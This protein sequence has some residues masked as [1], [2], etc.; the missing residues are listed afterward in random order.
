MPPL[1]KVAWS[2]LDRSA[3]ACQAA[4]LALPVPRRSPLATPATVPERP[5]GDAGRPPRSRLPPPVPIRRHARIGQDARRA[6]IARAHGRQPGRRAGALPGRR[7]GDAAGG[8]EGG[9]PAA[10]RSGR[11]PRPRPAGGPAAD[12]PAPLRQQ[13]AVG[14]G[15]SGRRGDAHRSHRS[16]GGRSAGRAVPPGPSAQRHGRVSP[17]VPTTAGL[18]R[19]AAMSDRASLPATGC[20]GSYPCRCSLASSAEKHGDSHRGTR[21]R[22]A[23]CWRPMPPWPWRCLSLLGPARADEAPNRPLSHPGAARAW[24][25]ARKLDQSRRAQ[26]HAPGDAPVDGAQPGPGGAADDHLL[27]PHH[28]RAEPVAAGRGN[29]A[30]SA[31]PGD[32]RR[33]PCSSP[34]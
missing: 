19:R 27:R 8:A 4:P 2:I 30:A 18:D 9:R 6:A 12:A 28:R 17:S 15:H 34:C 11:G 21:L 31:Q 25:P 20:R 26:L 24:R 32:H 23:V 3:V 16:V 29:A 10:R 5:P 22:L 14:L 13:A 7:L 33:W 1:R